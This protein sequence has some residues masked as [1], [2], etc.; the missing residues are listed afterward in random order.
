MTPEDVRDA[1]IARAET[2]GPRIETFKLAGQVYWIKRPER[3]TLQLMLQKG[4]PMRAFAQEVAAYQKFAKLGLPV[5]PIIAVGATYLVTKD[6]GTQLR[7]LAKTK[8][9]DLPKALTAAARGL[10][11]FHKAGVCH[12]RPSLKDICWK[13]EKISFLD[14]ER[15]TRDR[16]LERAIATD[17]ILFIY[18]ISVETAGDTTA[19]S[20]ARDAYIAAGGA[21]QWQKAQS[22]ARGFFYL[23][24]ILWPAAK[25]YKKSRELSAVEPLFK[26]MKG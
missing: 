2:A 3:A 14:F 23:R 5:V 7:Q 15:A 10:A 26:F 18:S 19:M 20:T 11:E 25:V 6:N 16:N 21:A 12:G 1:L 13:N 8:S 9:Q 22:R 4:D 17:I 24:A